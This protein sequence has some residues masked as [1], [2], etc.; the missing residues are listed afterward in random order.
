M[1]APYDWLYSR[2]RQGRARGPERARALLDRLGA[3]DSTFSSLR[4]IGTNGKGSTC[5]MLE[6]GLIAVGE[7]VG[8][9]TSP[10]L[11]HFE[12]R[13]RIGGAELD[14]LRS[15]AFVQWAQRHAPK[16]AFFELT[17]GLAC[18]EFARAGVRWAVMEA[19]V[20]GVSDGTQALSNVRAVLITNVALDHTAALGPTLTEIARDKAGA[21]QPGVPLLT[22]AQGEGLEVIEQVAAERNAPFYTRR[23]AIPS[24]LPCPA[25]QTWPGPHQLPERSAGAGNPAAAGI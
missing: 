19:G 18:L 10:H 4:V 24:S 25:P 7:R 12:E 22:T 2:T 13:I 8:C 11:T 1:P 16:A 23:T 17:L 21:A 6:A 14:P 20:G 9:F 15:A 5:A 3:P